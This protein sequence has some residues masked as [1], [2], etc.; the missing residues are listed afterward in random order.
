[1]SDKLTLEWLKEMISHEIKNMHESTSMLLESPYNITEQND[2]AFSEMV[3][4]LNGKGGLSTVVIMTPEN[5]L[6]KQAEAS[7]NDERRYDFVQQMGNDGHSIYPIIGKYGV[8]ENSYIIPGM[9]RVDAVKYGQ[10]YDQDSVIYGERRSF[11]DGDAIEY[12][13]IYTVEGTGYD[14]DAGLRYVAVHG[15]KADQRDDLFSEY[16]GM[17]FFIPFYEES[18][19]EVFPWDLENQPESEEAQE[20]EVSVEP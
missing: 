20:P 2:M 14:P 8:E 15:Q 7:E 11:A 16:N 4:M 12:Q 17:K 10:Q 9:S 1:M 18:Y 5:P 3:N 13:M 19:A 6:G